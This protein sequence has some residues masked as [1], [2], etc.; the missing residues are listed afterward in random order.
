VKFKPKNPI[1]RVFLHHI[2]HQFKITT[3]LIVGK[4]SKKQHFKGA[5]ESELSREGLPP[6][7]GVP[8]LARLRLIF[9][10]IF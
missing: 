10:V 3:Q 1:N 4:Q 5:R 6:T 9:N 2:L 8:L 7:I